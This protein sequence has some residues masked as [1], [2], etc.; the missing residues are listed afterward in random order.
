MLDAVLFELDGVVADTRLARRASLLQALGENGVL[1]GES[2][3]DAHCAGLPAR[4][5]VEAALSLQEATRDETTI[6]L[7]VH[8]AE[9]RFAEW[10]DKGIS[11]A[12]GAAE[13]VRELHGRTRLG[14]V[15]RAN[16]REAELVLSL[17][18]LGDAFECVIADDDAH[19][20]KPAPAPYV[21]ALARLARRGSLRPER[22]LALEC[23]TPGIRSAR[24]ARAR[25][26][27]VG[28]LPAHVAMEADALVGSLEGQ[29]LASFDALLSPNGEMSR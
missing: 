26:I 12:R 28:A 2:D 16:R 10:L 6:A 1:V 21:A 20:S 11:L 4:A 25:C 14:I 5:A 27:A 22:V 17:A 7:M 9:Q 13:L 3:F 29:S 19:P 15:T 23:S 8:R 24:A 18:E